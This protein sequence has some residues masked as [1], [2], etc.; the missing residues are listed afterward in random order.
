MKNTVNKRIQEHLNHELERLELELDSDV[1]VYTG[2]IVDGIENDFLR[3]VEE[4]SNE[5]KGLDYTQKK[6]NLILTT[7]GDRKSVV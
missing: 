5:T 6:I 2:P 4:L 7:S 1:L 3:I